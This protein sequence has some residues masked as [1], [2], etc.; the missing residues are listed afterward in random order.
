MVSIDFKEA[1]VDPEDMETLSDMTTQAINDAL[2]QIDEA[3]KKNNGSICREI[4]FLRKSKK[5]M[6]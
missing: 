6:T 3:T 4:T 5:T 2:A 1:V